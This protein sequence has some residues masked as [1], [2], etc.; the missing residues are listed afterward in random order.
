MTPIA[1]AFSVVGLVWVGYGS[2]WLLRNRSYQLTRIHH[3]FADLLGFP[4]EWAQSVWGRAGVPYAFLFPNLLLF[5]LFTFLPLLLN[6]YV[7]FTSGNSI[8]LFTRPWVGTENYAQ[9]FDCDSIFEPRT[10]H[11]SGFNFW[12]GMFNTFTFVVVAVP[13]LCAVSLITA[14]V[15]NL[16]VR[17]RGFWRALFFY[18]VMLSP[19]VIAN[20]WQWVLHRKGVLNATLGDANGAVNSLAGIAGIDILAT[21]IVGILLLI[22]AERSWRGGG[23]K[24]TTDNSARAEPSLPWASVFVALVVLVTWWA[25]PLA[26]FGFGGGADVDAD[27]SRGLLGLDPGLWLALALGTLLLWQIADRR[28]FARPLVA[29][30]F[31]LSMVALVLIQFD[32]VFDLGRFRPVN[33]LVTPKTGWPFFWLVFVYTWHHM[34]FYM[35]ILLAGLQAI[36]RDLYEAAEMDAATPFRTFSRITFPL[37]MPTFTVVLVLSLIKAFQVFDEVYTLTG[38]G[39]GRE[40]FMVVQYIFETAFTTSRNYGM[41]AAGSVIMA[42]F[43][44]VFTLGQLWLTRRNSGI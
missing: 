15:V 20:I 10:C 16:T 9:L 3:F 2:V 23:V 39:P 25:S 12:T 27:H 17:G 36:P 42:V 41:A 18:P 7:S 11:A 24:F 38:G 5:G 21:V 34:G 43:I 37:L 1:L 32:A 35:L 22:T 26:A 40:T 33:W 29:I 8:S 30:C 31:V 13:V 4:V 28:R 6:F 14:L 44:A 19:V